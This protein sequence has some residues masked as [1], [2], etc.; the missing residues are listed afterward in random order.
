[1]M[2]KSLALAAAAALVVGGMSLSTSPA[3]ANDQSEN[4]SQHQNDQ[5]Q[6]APLRLPDGVK[7]VDNPKA[8][9]MRQIVAQVTQAAITKG[10]FDDL[11]ERFVDQDRNRVGEYA[12]SDFK[13]LDGRIEQLQRA[14]QQKY[15]QEFDMDAAKVLASAQAVEGEITDPVALLRNWPVNVTTEAAQAKANPD[16]PANTENTEDNGNIEKGRGIG[17]LR[18]PADSMLPMLDI[19][20]IDEAGG[21]KI[22]LPNSRTGKQIHDDLL[23]HLTYLGEHADQWPSNVEDAYRMFAHHVMMAVYGVD[24][25]QQK[26]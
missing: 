22:D 12:E 5:A 11:V 25:S 10:G 15:H 13:D 24:V 17:V 3:W 26:T 19:S 23:T 2:K 18:L 14:W 8:D 21:W 20:L 7:A 4:H 1:M 9:D 6:A 16:E